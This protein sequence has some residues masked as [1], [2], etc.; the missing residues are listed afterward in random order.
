MIFVE[1]YHMRRQEKAIKSR[2]RM[3]DLIE[4]Q[5]HMTIAMC[6]GSKPYLVTIN[7]SFD[8]EGMCLYFHCARKGKKVDFLKANPRVWGQ[9]MKDDGYIEGECDYAYKTVM[10][11]GTTEFVTDLEEKRRALD[12]M[13][14]KLEKEDPVGRKARSLTK[15]KLEKTL[16]C[17]IRVLGLSGKERLRSDYN[18]RKRR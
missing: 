7:H 2:K 18:Q 3:L 4:Q 14:D 11:S 6:K 8:K 1:K 13:I 10:F 9:V 15:E 5:Q 12:L 16:I 17:R